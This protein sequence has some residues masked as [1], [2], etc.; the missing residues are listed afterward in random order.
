MEKVMTQVNK[1]TRKTVG[2]E[3]FLDIIDDPCDTETFKEHRRGS[4]FYTQWVFEVNEKYFPNNPEL[5]GFW[6]SNSFI[7]DSE[8][9]FESSYIEELDRVEKKKIM[10]E[11][12][13][14]V[15]VE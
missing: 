11:T 14:W 3:L 15:V 12:T 1:I 6:L 4:N 8:Y 2:T 13:D 7:W 10:V 9:G 5:W